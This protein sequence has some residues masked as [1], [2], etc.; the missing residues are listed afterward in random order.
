M[1]TAPTEPALELRGAA[2]GMM[3]CKEPGILI[4]GPAGTGKTRGVLEKVYAC[5]NKYAGMRALLVRK[6]RAS[7]TESVLVTWESKVVLPQ[8]PCL[9]GPGRAHRQAYQFTNGSTVVVGGMDN[10]DRV[11]STEYDLIAFFEATEGTEDDAEKLMTRLRNGVMPYQQIVFD[12]N[13]GAPTHWL[14]RWADAGRL[15]R[16]S[17]RHEDNP[18]VTG[19]YLAVLD[20]LTGH[21]HARLRL[22]LWAAAEGVVYPEW[23]AS[24]HLIDR[25]DI[26]QSWRRFRSIDFGYTNPFVCQ[27]WA[28]DGDGRMYLYRELYR[29]QRTVR[30]HAREIIR[31]SEGEHIE[32]TVT[33]HDAEDRATLDQEGIGSIPA[34][35]DVTVGIQAVAARL[36][37][38]GDGK[39]RLCVLRDSLVSP[40]PAMR[41]AKRPTCT[42]EEFDGYCWAETKEGR[43]V[44][45]EPVKVDD[46]GMDALRYA[47]MY[48]DSGI[49]V[50]ASVVPAV[51]APE[52]PKAVS[53]AERRKDPNF[54]FEPVRT[55]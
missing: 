5:A 22:G 54:G 23:D 51:A 33:D 30:D 34:K 3:L 39:P 41:E 16:F 14:K 11:M 44:K 20:G 31:L 40:D 26:P 25:F 6:T 45:E 38:A 49:V 18:S 2:L 37:R 32:A 55:W 50:G 1:T 12:C 9:K 10:A 8:D 36:R 42:A 52:A 47:V 46:H 17:S 48:L 29:S 27:W 21:R 35:K 43:P 53:W 19:E 7:L 28:V 24:V 4:D 15:R 13:P